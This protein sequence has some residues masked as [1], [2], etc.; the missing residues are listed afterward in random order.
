MAGKGSLAQ[1]RKDYEA[2]ARANMGFLEKNK[3]LSDLSAEESSVWW[4]SFLLSLLIILIEIGPVLSKL[5]MPLGPYD[6]ALAREELI[7]MAADENEMRKNKEV[8]Y[9]KR[10]AF[11]Q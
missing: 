3:A 7:Q 2:Q 5:I 10:K 1:T 9:A 4:T 6:I 8:V 11:F